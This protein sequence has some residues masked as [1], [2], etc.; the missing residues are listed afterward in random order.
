V[1]AA[2]PGTRLA[3]AL[4]AWEIQAHRTLAANPD[5]ADL[6]RVARVQALITSTT[7][8]LT[9]AAARK[10]HIDIDVLDRLAPALEADQ[11]AWSRLAK[12]WGELTRPS[13]RTDPALVR[14][15]SELRAAIA[16]AGLRPVAATSRSCAAGRRANRSASQ[17][18]EVPRRF[19]HY[20]SLPGRACQN[21]IIHGY[22]L[23]NHAQW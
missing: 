20:S 6:V 18:R 3:T 19:P 12:R 15:A 4:A 23:M 11:V 21:N 5:P 22:L 16:A 10:R 8:I 13:Q 1:K 14:S 7:S 17:G 2:T 9:E